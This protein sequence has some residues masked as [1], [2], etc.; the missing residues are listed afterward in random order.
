MRHTCHQESIVTDMYTGS[1]PAEVVTARLGRLEQELEAWR[2]GLA[3]HLV[4]N[5]G[6]M[7]DQKPTP[8]IMSLQ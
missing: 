2:D 6:E 3:P 5:P 1:K 7:S 4:F 8:M